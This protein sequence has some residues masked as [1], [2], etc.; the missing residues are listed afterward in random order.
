MIDILILRNDV[1][2]ILED[3][4]GTYTFPDRTTAPSIACLPRAAASCQ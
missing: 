4:L 3:L 1:L 2:V